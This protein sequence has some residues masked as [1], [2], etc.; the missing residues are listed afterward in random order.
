MNQYANRLLLSALVTFISGFTCLTNAAIAQ[1]SSSTATQEF[2]TN[3][4]FPSITFPAT[5]SPAEIRQEQ[6]AE[7]HNEQER[8]LDS[9]KTWQ[10][11]EDQLQQEQEMAVPE[12]ADNSSYAAPGSETPEQETP[13]TLETPF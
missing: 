11:Q 4:A 6:E 3:A 10:E 5:S 9:S 12:N 1:Q 7:L 13:N 8:L 2:E